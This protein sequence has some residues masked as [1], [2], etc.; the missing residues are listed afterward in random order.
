MAENEFGAM[1][2]SG[3]S[4]KQIT[5]CCTENYCFIWR[6]KVMFVMMY[7]DIMYE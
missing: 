6:L 7:P 3:E 1:C 4:Q 5:V 2:F